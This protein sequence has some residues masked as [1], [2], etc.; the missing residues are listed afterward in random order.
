MTLAPPGCMEA[1]SRGERRP[2][3]VHARRR[4]GGE[5]TC[6]ARQLPKALD[7]MR[8]GATRYPF[9]DWLAPVRSEAAATAVFV[10]LVGV[11]TLLPTDL[12]DQSVPYAL[13]VLA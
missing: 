1:S 5:L 10:L 12:D 8:Q 7:I 4:E 11:L 13:L 6:M 3:G 9:A 2:R